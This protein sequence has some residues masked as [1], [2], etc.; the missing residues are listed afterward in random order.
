MQEI[1]FKI[2]WWICKSK[3]CSSPHADAIYLLIIA[4]ER[5]ELKAC[6]CSSPRCSCIASRWMLFPKWGKNNTEKQRV[7]MQHMTQNIYKNSLVCKFSSNDYGIDSFFPPSLSPFPWASGKR[8][9]QTSKIICYNYNKYCCLLGLVS[10]KAVSWLML[11]IKASLLHVWAS[12]LCNRLCRT[13]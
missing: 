5:Y 10:L 8:L 3:A 1:S 7:V 12:W 4:Q 9:L 13:C 6:F 2:R 11:A